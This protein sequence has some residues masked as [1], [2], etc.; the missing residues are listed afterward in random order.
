MNY[1]ILFRQTFRKFINTE[2]RFYKGLQTVYHYLIAMKKIRK[3]KHLSFA[4]GITKHCNL[5]C[6]YCFAFSPLADEYCYDIDIFK[7]D[8][9]RISELT[10]RKIKDMGIA[11]GEPLLHPRITEFFDI[12]RGCFDYYPKKSFG[13][14]F[15]ITNGTLLARQP[16]SFWNNCAKNNIE[17]RITKYPIKLDID[18]VRQIACKHGVRLTYYSETDKI[19]KRMD[20]LK[21]DPKGRQNIKD[22]FI[23]CFLSTDCINLYKGR[24]YTCC[25]PIYIDSF[26]KYFNQ[27]ISLTDDSSIDIYKVRNIDEMFDFLR[28]PIPFCRYCDWKNTKTNMPWRVSKKEITEWT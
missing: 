19:E 28:K 23:R 10:G 15:I 26:N 22:A 2:S 8:V 20:R 6:A 7:K 11:G 12:A 16:E 27:N 21:L 17:I 3:H 9:F 5:N 24:M 14:I 18:A 1:S 25:I 13:N 4:M